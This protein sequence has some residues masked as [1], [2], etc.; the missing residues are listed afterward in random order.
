MITRKQAGG[1]TRAH[2]KLLAKRISVIV[3]SHQ[4]R[5]TQMKYTDHTEANSAFSIG[6]LRAECAS[7]YP[8]FSERNNLREVNMNYAFQWDLL[9]LLLLLLILNCK[10]VFTRWQ[11]YCD[12]SQH[13]HAHITPNN[14]PH[15]KHSTQSYTN[16]KG[17]ITHNELNAKKEQS[18]P[19]NRPWRPIGLWNVEDSI[20]SRQS[21][22]S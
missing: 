9:L 4:T 11:W 7:L 3:S 6:L 8:E 1:K 10:W 22:R 17:R 18:F 12:L 19:C 15:S 13:T 16:N 2:R 14:T 20:L 21:V 5:S